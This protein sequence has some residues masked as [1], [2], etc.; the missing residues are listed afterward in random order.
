MVTKVTTDLSS[1]VNSLSASSLLTWKV[2]SMAWS[3]RLYF[4]RAYCSN[5]DSSSKYWNIKIQI[6]HMY[7]AFSPWEGDHTIELPLYSNIFSIFPTMHILIKTTQFHC[8]LQSWLILYGNSYMYYLGI[9]ICII[10]FWDWSDANTS[11]FKYGVHSARIHV[12]K[13]VH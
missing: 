10:L 5:L 4:C 11:F 3:S 8:W 13:N 9:R 12:F 6:K 2:V 7:I 1:S